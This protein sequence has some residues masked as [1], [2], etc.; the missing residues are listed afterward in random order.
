MS[1]S[2]PVD[3]RGAD[4]ALLKAKHPG[5]LL[6][7]V[8]MITLTQFLDATIANVALPHMQ[9][10]LGASSESIAWVLTSFIIVSAVFTPI[11]GWLSER[12]GSRRLFLWS[13][14]AFLAS[15]A[16]CGAST[17]LAEMV[18]F[19]ALQGLSVAF[20]APLAQ[21]VLFDI[22]PPSKHAS[23]MALFGLIIMVAPITG[24]FLGGY[25]TEYLNWRWIYYVNL[26]IG[27][28]ALVIIWWLLPSRPLTRRKLDLTGF[29]LLAIA[30]CGVQLM[31]DRGQHK[32]WFDS[33]EIVFELVIAIS[34]FWVFLV[35]TRFTKT[36]LFNPALFRDPNFMVGAL[37]MVVLGVTV[38]G[39]STILPI[40]FQS[41]Y[42]Y[43]VIDAG[44][45][46][47]PRGFGVIITTLLAPR[48]MKRFDFRAI[49]VMGYCIA[50]WSL[51]LMSGWSLDA[52]ARQFVMASFIQGLGVGFIMT[53]MNIVAFATLRDDLRPEGSA[54]LGLFRNIGG[55]VGVSVI[56]TMLARNQQVSHADLAAHVT[57][58]T[59]PGMDLSAVYDRLPGIG[60]GGLAVID[61]EVNRQA[62]MIAFIDNFYMLIWVLAAFAPLVLL[63]RKPKGFAGGPVHMA[64]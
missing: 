7:A 33:P 14:G 8:M 26:P 51:M 55:S 44:L 15:S 32:D 57:S 5:L 40:M 35:H 29:A 27:I 41:L 50:G 31:L 4:E 19:R 28:P 20:F 46:M 39:V 23:N 60:A 59:I 21:T 37:F 1:A 34:A 10:A 11:T 18:A 3:R 63:L 54:L 2:T 53:P 24:P 13:A 61:A 12:V 38:I 30:L 22:S 43:S 64:E 48:L 16:A 58:S 52:G 36:P 47:A 17:S 25:L 56:V 9:T 62:M 6:V 45:L 49:V 42:R